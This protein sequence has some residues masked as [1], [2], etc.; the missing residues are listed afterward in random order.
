MADRDRALP[1]LSSISRGLRADALWVVATFIGGLAGAVGMIGLLLELPGRAL[2]SGCLTVLEWSLRQMS[3]AQAIEA[4]R[5]ETQSGSVH[6]SAVP[7]RGC[8]QTSPG[9]Q[10]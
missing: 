5:A 1:A 3:A 6:E 10:S 4:R 8:A 9:D 2:R 7:D